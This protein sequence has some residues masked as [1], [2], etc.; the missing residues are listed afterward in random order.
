M[1]TAR[2]LLEEESGLA[3]NASLERSH[4]QI[5]FSEGQA[6]VRCQEGLWDPDKDAEAKPLG[7]AGNAL[8]LEQVRTCPP[9]TP[10]FSWNERCLEHSGRAP[11]QYQFIWHHTWQSCGAYEILSV[12]ACQAHFQ[13]FAPHIERRK[14]HNRANVA[15]CR[16]RML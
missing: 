9:H 8:I 2:D 4:W 7:P 14:P 5:S 1:R 10:P 3:W 6:P 11:L 16:K 12:T 13:A 15:P